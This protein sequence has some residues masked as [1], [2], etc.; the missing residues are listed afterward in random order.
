MELKWLGETARMMIMM[1]MMM[2]VCVCVCVETI[3]YRLD[4]GTG[5]FF[6]PKEEQTQAPSGIQ[7]C[8]R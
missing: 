1:M 3:L 2:C 4:L 8:D 6:S 5:D 7:K